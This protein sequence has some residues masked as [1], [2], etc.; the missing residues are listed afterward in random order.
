MRPWRGWRRGPCRCIA[1]SSPLRRWPASRRDGARRPR[2]RGTGRL[3]RHRREFLLGAAG[4]ACGLA[5]APAGSRRSARD[6]GYGQRGR[7]VM[8]QEETGALPFDELEAAYERIAET[9]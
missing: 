5:L 3:R 1:W 7:T 4:P 6:P 9:I 8:A 2:R